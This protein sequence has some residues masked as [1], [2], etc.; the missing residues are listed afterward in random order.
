MRPV[1][2]SRT[3]SGLTAVVPVDYLQNAFNVNVAAVL[4]GSV[5]FTLEHTHDN[6]LDP[7]VTPTWFA[8]SERIANYTKAYTNPI[9][10][11]RGNVSAGAGT[12][13]LTVLQ[14]NPR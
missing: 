5:T 14:G 10:A 8:D 3:G 4:T 7:T 12:I 2:V 9:R 6:V 1:V 13:T 11:I